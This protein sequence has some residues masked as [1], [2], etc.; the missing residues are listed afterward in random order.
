MRT[1]GI[2][3][4]VTA[5]AIYVQMILGGIMLIERTA[6]IHVYFG[7]GITFLALI[8]AILLWRVKPRSKF[9]R[10]GGILFLI[11]VGLQTEVLGPA[12][13]TTGLPWFNPSLLSL[14]DQLILAAHGMNAAVVFA[15]SVALS[16]WAVRE[17]PR[18]QVTK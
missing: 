18:A 15:I 6:N 14:N 13:T 4:L 11:L 1:A 9:L 2:A 3:V 10:R 12:I 17:L 16:V 8:A 5:G 7:H